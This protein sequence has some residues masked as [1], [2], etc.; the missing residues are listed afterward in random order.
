MQKKKFIFSILL[1]MIFSITL[2]AGCGTKEANGKP[3]ETVKNFLDAFI[4]G[5]MKTANTY[6]LDAEDVMD[7]TSEKEEDSYFSKISYELVDGAEID[8]DNATV[9]TKITSPDMEQAMSLFFEAMMASVVNGEEEMTEEQ[10]QSKFDE[11]LDSDEVGKIT[12]EVDV[13]LQKQDGKWLIDADVEFMN[14]VT[15]NMINML[16]EMQQMEE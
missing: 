6:L 3:E 2:L 11:L 8:G 16:N 15:G 12:N 10:M 9:K 13:K 4:E 5:D 1:T 7:D 14:A